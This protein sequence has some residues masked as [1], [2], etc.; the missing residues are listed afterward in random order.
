MNYMTSNLT[1]NLTDFVSI[2]RFSLSERKN[3]LSL[4]SGYR[5]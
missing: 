4:F 2:F 3:R 1:K 5:C